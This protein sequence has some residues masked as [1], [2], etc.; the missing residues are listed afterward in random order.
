MNT[1]KVENFIK[2][3]K[4]EI[5][6]GTVMIVGGLVIFAITKKK[7]ASLNKA[8]EKLTP[9]KWNSMDIPSSG[10]GIIDSVDTNGKWIDVIANNLTVDDLSKLGEAF[11][12]LDTVTGETGVS[13]LISLS[14]EW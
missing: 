13:A 1:T 3:H 5:V 14:N 2:K 12:E 11:K 8:V 7:P 10:V 4:K 9:E 6:I